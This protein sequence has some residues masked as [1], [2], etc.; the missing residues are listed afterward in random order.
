A[1][2]LRR[3]A[4]GGR[5]PTLQ[6]DTTGLALARDSLS[7]SVY[8]AGTARGSVRNFDLRGRA[9]L[10]SIVARGNTVGH[11]RVEYAVIAGGTPNMAIAAGAAFDTIQAAGFQLDSVAV[12]TAFRRPSGET[13]VQIFQDSARSYDLR[14]EFV[15]Q[16]DERQ[17][18]F[19]DLRLRFDTTVWAAARP[20][21]IRWGT[22]GIRI[23]T[24]DLR[25][26]EA[27]RIYANGV[28]S[29]EGESN[30]ELDIAGLE[31]AHLAALMQ[32]DIGAEGVLALTARVEGTQ[33]NPRL[34][35]AMGLADATYRGAPI[36]DIRTTFAYANTELTAHVEAVHGESKPLAVVDALLPVN[37]AMAGHSGPRL[38]ERPMRVDLVADSLPL[39]ALPK[40]TDVVA[41]IR[42]RLIG[43]LAARGTPRDPAL[44][45]ALAVDFASFRVV[46]VGVTFRD[47]FGVVRMRGDSLVI[48]S[49]VAQSDGPV[50]I[51]GALDIREISRPGFALQ[52]TARHATVLDTERGQL[53][54][55]ADIA[56][57]GPFN[58]V[59]ITGD[60]QILDGV[61][62]IPEPEG[63]DVI[64]TADPQIFNVI[65]TSLTVAD[66]VLP[67][68]NP[69]LQNL[70]VAINLGVSRDTW[71]RS[72]DANV[73]IFSTGD[74]SIQVDRSRQAIT[75]D[76]VVNTERGEYTFLTRR[77]LLSRG[78]VTFIGDPE[79]N[80]LLQLIGQHEVRLPGQEALVIQVVVGGT[81]RR[82]RVTLESTAQP[83]L[84]QTDLLSYLAFGRSSSTLMQQQGSSLSGPAAGG[85]QLV[86][87]V[88][89]LA[90]RQMAAVAIGTVSGQLEQ[91]AARQ[92]G[93]DVFNVTPADVPSELSISGVEGLL[94]GTEIEVGKYVNRRTFVAMDVRP[95]GTVPGARIAHRFSTRTRI[96][97]SF[98]PRFLLR[99]PSLEVDRDPANPVGVFGAFVIREWR[100]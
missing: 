74:L 64:N 39:D 81:M 21:T 87:D 11:G 56:V 45:G 30:A 49:L 63:R 58:A 35:G 78:S 50:R 84:S 82:P 52:L 67:N 1:T 44:A 96:E 4:M 9:A 86:G 85:G 65:D 42:G 18:R 5:P 83:P 60:A 7:G 98:E 97:A 33:T 32:G 69:L 16:P 41:N 71:L 36:P 31:V 79:I 40:F 59:E 19:T 73:E 70:R 62:Y 92:F 15:L 94:R 38:L 43:T 23:D 54:A 20:A 8:V 29:T 27:G 57:R 3:L 53:H 14:A 26:A 68:Q 88:A 10:S 48:D 76:G 55:D 17:L 90:T 80:P 51:T 89:G 100:F 95:T 91:N 47:I 34:R 24:L 25:S 28:I 75:L 2:E 22:R 72:A 66:E 37:L 46:P 6:L 93:V 13:R 99:T 12:Q 77:F 61:V